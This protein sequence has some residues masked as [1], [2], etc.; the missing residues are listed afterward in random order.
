MRAALLALRYRSG[1]PQLIHELPPVSRTPFLHFT[2]RTQLTLAIAERWSGQ[3]PAWLE[4]EVRIRLEKNTVR[5]YNL[6]QAWSEI[7]AVLNRKSLEYTVLKGFSS[8]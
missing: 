5:W 8:I 7:T 4:D 2:D 1:T 6:K 3:L